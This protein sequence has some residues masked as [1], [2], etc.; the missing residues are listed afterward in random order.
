MVGY[1]IFEWKPEIK[2][3][4]KSPSKKKNDGIEEN[5]EAS[6]ALRLLQKVSEKEEEKNLPLVP[7]QKVEIQ[8]MR[9]KR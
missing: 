9:K 5:I 6:L 2:S 3:L 4:M 1:R 8:M 7:K